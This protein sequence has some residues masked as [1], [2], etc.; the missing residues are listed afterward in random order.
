MPA[1][2]HLPRAAQTLVH[3]RRRLS[4]HARLSSTNV[5]AGDHFYLAFLPHS[6]TWRSDA[7]E[8]ARTERCQPFTEVPPCKVW[9]RRNPVATDTTFALIDKNELTDRQKTIQE[10]D[11]FMPPNRWRARAYRPPK[12]VIEKE[13]ARK[14]A[15]LH[16]KERAAAAVRRA[17]IVRALTLTGLA[18]EAPSV[19]TAGA[20]DQG[21]IKTTPTAAGATVAS[22]GNSSD[23]AGSTGAALPQQKKEEASSSSAFRERQMAW[24]ACSGRKTDGNSNTVTPASPS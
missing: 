21:K 7:P 15:E 3:R 24:L 19:Q 6:H 12:W 4:D 16:A 23:I 9:T 5:E 13:K 2:L 1:P 10:A 14:A 11:S 20:A 17:S 18:T 22:C 8:M